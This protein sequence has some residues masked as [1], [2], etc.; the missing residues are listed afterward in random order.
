MDIAD[1]LREIRIER[2]AI[3]CDYL[4]EHQVM[5]AEANHYNNDVDK[6]DKMCEYFFGYTYDKD[7]RTFVEC[8][9]IGSKNGYPAGSLSNFAPHP[10]EMDGVHCSSM[11]GFLQSLKF[12]SQDMQQHVCTL[13][14]MAAKQKGAG[15][16]WYR[17]QT[18][19]WK[20]K[21]Y[22]RDSEDYQLLLN[23]AYNRLFENTGFKNAL[24]ATNNAVLTHSLGKSKKSE[25]ILTA[26]EFC[27]RLTHLRDIG[28][29]PE[30]KQVQEKLF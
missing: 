7:E 16:K 23:K 17:T 6:F 3:F 14:G 5:D 28:K 24:M 8:M 18:L 22:K 11:E 21:E 13:V 1:I 25:T 4:R 9:D 12:E 30:K 26:K 19:Y 15:K 10:F 27:S 2:V 29:L 20:G